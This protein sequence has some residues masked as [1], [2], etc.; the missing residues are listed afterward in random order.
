MPFRFTISIDPITGGLSL[1]DLER[2]LEVVGE[3]SAPDPTPA[4]RSRSGSAVY[5]APATMRQG[6]AAAA[7][8]S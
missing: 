3:V 1:N 5:A 6:E 2:V 7:H 8:V 4:L